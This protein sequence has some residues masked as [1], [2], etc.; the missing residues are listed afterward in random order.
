MSKSDYNRVANNEIRGLFYLDDIDSY[1]YKNDD[2][3]MDVG[4]KMIHLP[5]KTEEKCHDF[6]SQIKNQNIALL[7]LY[8]R[9]KHIEQSG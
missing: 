7:R 3:E 2:D 5:T 4:V 6:D 1:I 9:I 8:K